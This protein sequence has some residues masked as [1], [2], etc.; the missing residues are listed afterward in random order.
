MRFLTRSLIGL[1]LF[2]LTIAFLGYAFLLFMSA[3]ESENQT[4]YKKARKSKERS[5]S[6][7]V[8]TIENITVSPKILSYGEVISRRTLE[9]RT[10]SSGEL[11][12]VAERFQ[13]GD[14]ISKGAKLFTINPQSAI[15]A[16]DVSKITKE[17]TEAELVE[18]RANYDLTILDLLTAKNKLKLKLSALQRQRKLA[19][20]DI[21]SDSAVETIELAF[22][23]SEQNL[24]VKRNAVSRANARIGKLE[25]LLKRNLIAVAQA[26]RGLLETEYFSPFSGVLSNVSAIQGRLVNKNEK[27]GVLIDPSAL[28]VRFEVSATELL[29]MTDLKGH[30]LPLSITAKLEL[31]NEVKSFR[32]NLERVS[33]TV[34][35]GKTS[36]QLFASLNLD[37]KKML[38]PGD[39]LLIEI[40]EKS[41]DNV[42]LISS[43]AL[44]S[45][46]ELLILDEND[47]LD[48]FQVTLLRLQGNKV[49][50]S[51]APIGK[52]YVIQRTPQL[53]D[54]LKVKPIR[55]VI[56]TSN[57]LSPESVIKKGTEVK[58]IIKKMVQLDDKRRLKLI[59]FVESNTRMPKTVKSKLLEELNRE[60]VLEKT[61]LRLEKRMGSQ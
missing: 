2:L 54:G 8:N 39:F 46:Q 7:Y 4:S 26:T 60:K 20:N 3:F 52:E 17:D 47:R 15:D 14:S 51:G 44:N 29:R 43:D 25:I 49:I 41:L 1:A 34:A 40:E 11:T 18:A 10:P 6:V 56:D 38:R 58:A 36:R 35:E 24:E 59:N 45:N 5:F 61:L 53:A 22:S 21:V 16:L 28:E 13:E 42:S 55:N 12:S 48:K 23:D 50:V 33:A 30:L 57:K 27:L 32:G 19:E 31:D 9:I 37:G